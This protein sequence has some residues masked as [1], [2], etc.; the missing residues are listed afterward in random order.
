VCCG[1]SHHL[2]GI[3]WQAMELLGHCHTNPYCFPV[4]HRR[5][6]RSSAGEAGRKDEATVVLAG[7]DQPLLQ[8]WILVPAPNMGG[9]G[10]FYVWAA[11]REGKHW[12]SRRSAE[13]RARVELAWQPDNYLSHVG[14]SEAEGLT[15]TGQHAL[16]KTA[17][18]QLPVRFGVASAP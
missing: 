7:G 17:H 11:H 3:E 15:C 16:G 2:S 6:Y 9:P 10:H 8:H 13:G 4:F 1:F 5:S 12:L 14:S 18:Q